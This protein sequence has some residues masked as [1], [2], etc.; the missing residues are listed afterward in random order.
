MS[1]VKVAGAQGI[2][3]PGNYLFGATPASAAPL[4]LANISLDNTAD[5]I[6]FV[7]QH[8]NNSF[9]T[10]SITKIHFRCGTKTDAG[11][12]D[13]T[14]LTVTIEDV[15]TSA[16]PPGR[17]DGTP[18][19][20]GTV[21]IGS[22][23]NTTWN[24]VTLGTPYSAAYGEYFA[25]VFN[26]TS[27]GAGDIIQISRSTGICQADL[28]PGLTS[29]VAANLSGTYARTAGLPLVM[30]EYD[31][32]TFGTLAGCETLHTHNE[33]NL[34]TGGTAEAALEF[35]LPFPCQVAGGFWMPGTTQITT[36]GSMKMALYTGA[37]APDYGGA[38]ELAS[39]QDYLGEQIMYNSGGYLGP[40]ICL[41]TTG[42]ADISA[43]T[44]Y[45]MACRATAAV[46]C[47]LTY[48]DLVSASHR[49]STFFGTGAAYTTRTGSGASWAAAT[50]TRIPMIG[51]Y[52]VG[53]DD[54]AGGGVGG[55]MRVH[56]GMSG[57]MRG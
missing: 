13:D 56:P 45:R 20:S 5:F 49:E 24:S 25:V 35:Q 22:L 19:A 31:D 4:S 57:G 6:S 32:N 55:R 30:F 46:N 37:S 17:G 29:F 7:G 50:T 18:D 54:G 39:G 40:A 42:I 44:T 36:A 33:V 43:N 10:K 41:F 21:T 11:T 51:L 15:S 3:I 27:L 23:T 52:V 48:K 28:S 14:T 16:G 8:V 53:F 1:L 12:P 2:C 34:N 26:I 47:G 38:D 9:A